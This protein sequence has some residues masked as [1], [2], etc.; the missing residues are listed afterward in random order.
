M[1][2][3]FS[4]REGAGLLAAIVP[5]RV[6]LDDPAALRD[7]RR[8]ADEAHLDLLAASCSGSPLERSAGSPAFC[9]PP[10][11]HPA[12]HRCADEAADD[13]CGRDAP[14]RKP[15]RQLWTASQRLPLADSWLLRPLP[16]MLV[17]GFTFVI[18][19]T[20]SWQGQQVQVSTPASRREAT[21]A[22]CAAA[23]V[24]RCEV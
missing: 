3:S 6:R 10:L 17:E 23:A 24:E 2:T 22:G 18:S 12:A 1:R 19:V 21:S 20:G 14:E 16:T 4:C 15:S 8:V 13:L 7:L 5:R 11:C 9:H